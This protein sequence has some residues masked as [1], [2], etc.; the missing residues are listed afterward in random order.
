MAPSCDLG[1]D[2]LVRPIGLSAIE[3]SD[4][5]AFLRALNGRILDGS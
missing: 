4:L 3:K 2:K 5:V 1:L